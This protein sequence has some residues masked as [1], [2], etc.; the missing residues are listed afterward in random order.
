MESESAEF[1]EL[2]IDVLTMT[3]KENCVTVIQCQ[4]ASKLTKNTSQ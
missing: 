3:E 4:P 1:D 2:I